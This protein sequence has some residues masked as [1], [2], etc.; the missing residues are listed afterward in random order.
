MVRA[1]AYIANINDACVGTDPAGT[2]YCGRMIP[3]M[4]K[5]LATR[6]LITVTTEAS[7]IA[8]IVVIDSSRT[9]AC[10]QGATGAAPG[11]NALS[12]PVIR[13]RKNIL[14]KLFNRSGCSVLY[15]TRLQRNEDSCVDGF[16]HLDVHGSSL[17]WDTQLRQRLLHLVIRELLVTQ[18]RF[19]DAARNHCGSFRHRE[20]AL[21]KQLARLFAGKIQVQE[22]L[23]IG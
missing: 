13:R 20:V 18:I 2:R 9:L 22:A 3:T 4:E 21:H 1:A 17:R 12:L 19:T 11:L 10:K 23:R 5:P 8:F 16:V 15:R 6:T 7:R 14:H